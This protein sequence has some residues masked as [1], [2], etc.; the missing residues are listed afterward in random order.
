MMVKI[1]TNHIVLH[2]FLSEKY[3]QQLI[4][5][6]QCLS[7]VREDMYPPFQ[8]RIVILEYAHLPI[9]WVLFHDDVDFL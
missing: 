1:M 3:E 8:T 4:G 5:K 2:L 9:V 6:M 7:Y